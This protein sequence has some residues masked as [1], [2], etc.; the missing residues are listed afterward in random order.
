MFQFLP[1]PA[2]DKESLVSTF[3]PKSIN[4]IFSNKVLLY[5][6]IWPGTWYISQAG[7]ELTNCLSF[8]PP[9]F[10]KKKYFFVRISHLRT[11]FTSFPYSLPSATL[12]MF[13]H[14]LTN[15][16]P[17]LLYFL[18]SHAC[19][20]IIINMVSPFSFAHIHI[21]RGWQLGDG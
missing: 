8:C 6:L 7:L 20:C 2:M 19:M 15:S 10:F 5:S 12:P 18:L 9:L 16:R 13:P 11:V 4:N 21:I 3:S 17:L 14:S 1:L